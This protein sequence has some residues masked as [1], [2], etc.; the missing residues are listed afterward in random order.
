MRFID[1]ATIKIKAG[2][3]G[4]GCVSFFRGP[5]LPKGG[6]DG[7][8]GGRGGS[9]YLEASTNVQTLLDFKYKAHYE[10]DRGEHGMG[11]DCY[12]R[13]GEDLTL[14]VPVGTVVSSNDGAIE[15]DLSTPG[16]RLLVAKGGAGGLGNIHFK[17]SVRQTPRMATKGELGEERELRLELKVLS[18]MGLIGFPNVGKSSLLAAMTAATPKIANYPFTT[19]TPQLGVFRSEENPDQSDGGAVIADIPGLI[20]GAHQ[21]LGLGHKFL[22]HVSRSRMLLFVLAFD[23]QWRLEEMFQ[24]LRLE[25]KLFDHLLLNREYMIAVNKSDLLESDEIE[26]E[27]REAWRQEWMDF[28]ESHPEACLISATEHTGLD[29]LQKEISARLLSKSG[30]MLNC[31]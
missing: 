28:K 11:S 12:G 9:I 23:R 7:G 6:P 26:E 17:N 2:D 27:L 21:N 1:E 24:M 19:L 8:D 18:D 15:E 5:H 29:A 10:G 14:L 25:L 20:P 13:K 31:A 16:Q 30:H 3:G 4:N 22:K